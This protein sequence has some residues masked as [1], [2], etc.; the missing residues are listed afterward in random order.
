MKPSLIS[1]FLLISVVANSFASKSLVLLDTLAT[2]ETHSIFFKS[3]QDRGYKLT[4]KTADDPSLNL[5]K[6][7]E[8]AFNNLILFSPSVEEFGGSVNVE[9]ITNFI[10]NG[11]NVLV[12]G[13]SNVGDIIRELVSECGIEMDEEGAAIIDHHNYDKNDGGTHT[14]IA[15]DPANLL[16]AETIVGTKSN[17]PILFR[18]VGLIADA[19][20]LLLLPVLTASSSAYSYNPTA[21]VVE[22]PHA[23][24]KNMLMVAAIQTRNNARVVF[25]GSIDMFSD[26]FF[27]A[28]VEKVKSGSKPQKSVTHNK[29]GEQKPPTAYTITDQVI[30]SVVIEEWKADANEWVPF[31]AKDIQL[32]FVRIDPFV[33][34]TLVKSGNKYKAEFKLPDVY[35]VYQFK[36]DYKRIGWTYV[37]SS[38]QV[39]VRPLEHTQYERFIVS[40]YP[41][42]AG[43]FSMMF[44]VFIFSFVYLYHKDSSKDKTE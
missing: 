36:I 42:Y 2:R 23:V 32:E 40:A 16:N 25:S 9:A 35:G 12:A 27:L 6:Y 21:N 24:G 8:L 11:G 15:A 43:S 39:S 5:I 31:N 30:Y 20:N 28:N 26:E 22:Y 10:D 19:E 17:S 7:G 18:G 34:T 4:F 37:Y 3:L 1:F 41:Y 33:R 29:V 44:G 13:S 14:L 38:T